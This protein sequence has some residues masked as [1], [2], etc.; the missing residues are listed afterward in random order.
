MEAILSPWAQG[1]L[2]IWLPFSLPTY[3]S[4]WYF[5][6][7]YQTIYKPLKSAYPDVSCV[8]VRLPPHP[9]PQTHSSYKANRPVISFLQIHL[10][11]LPLAASPLG[12]GKQGD[13]P[14]NSRQAL[15]ALQVSNSLWTFPLANSISQVTFLNPAPGIRCLNSKW[16]INASGHNW[17][18]NNLKSRIRASSAYQRG[19][20]GRGQGEGKGHLWAKERRL[21]I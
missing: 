9:P 2:F 10:G 5:C 4:S 1:V 15:V 17:G 13:D 11:L 16:K 21:W 19:C 14:I 18:V 12:D 20:V 8:T 3:L 6:A 7:L